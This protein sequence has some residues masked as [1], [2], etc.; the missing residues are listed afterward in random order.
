MKRIASVVGI[1]LLAISCAAQDHAQIDIP[2]PGATEAWDIAVSTLLTSST[3]D[4]TFETLHL[5]TRALDYAGYH[6][7]AEARLRVLWDTP[8]PPQLARWAQS[9]DGEWQSDDA[10]SQG[11]ALVALSQHYLITGDDEWLR[12]AYPSIQRGAAWIRKTLELNDGLFP[13]SGRRKRPH[14]SDASNLWGRR[15]L[16]GAAELASALGEDSDASEMLESV[17]WILLSRHSLPWALYDP[18]TGDLRNPSR[19][20]SPAKTLPLDHWAY[21]AGQ[22]L[23]ENGV[24]ADFLQPDHWRGGVKTRYEFAITASRIALEWPGLP[25]AVA[26][27]KSGEGQTPV[28]ATA[29]KL[30]REFLPESFDLMAQMGNL[31]SDVDEL[32]DR[33]A[34]L[35]GK[36]YVPRRITRLRA[37][38]VEANDGFSVTQAAKFIIDM[39]DIL[40]RD[41]DDCLTL[42]PISPHVWIRAGGEIRFSQ[43]PTRH[44]PVSC[45]ARMTP[46][47]LAS[48]T[49][50]VSLAPAPASRTVRI[51]QPY[52]A[53]SRRTGVDVEGGPFKRVSTDKHFVTVTPAQQEVTVTIH[54]G[55]APPRN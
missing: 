53:G 19:D 21:D 54:Y 46:E 11:L 29:I 1:A 6:D 47:R 17:Q 35:E 31:A 3:A 26:A 10:R 5:T 22:E 42:F 50:R 18:G 52:F 34:Q 25:D 13:K 43:L 41:D 44:G 27:D 14:P 24:V 20:P 12:R 38:I 7:E 2:E 55:P 28:G 49:L 37:S 33:V 48:G 45:T 40:V 8:V 15:G 51:R 30:V 36:D 16:E 4:L 23:I 39:R 32:D 9:D